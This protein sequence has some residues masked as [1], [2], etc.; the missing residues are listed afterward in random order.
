MGDRQNDTVRVD[1]DRQI[2]LE[3]HSSTVTS[4]AGLLAYRELDDALRLTN[5]AA[6]GLQDTRTG[7]NTQHS[8]VA[9]LRQSIYSRL[10]GYEDV[11][12]AERLGLDPAMRIV[13][14]GRAKDTQAASTSEMARF[15]TETLSTTENLKHLMD[16]SGQWIDQAHHHRKLTKLILDMDSSVSETYGNQEGSAYNGHFGCTCYHP[17][18]LFNQFGDLE[19]CMLRPGNVH[20]ADDWRS[21]LMPVIARY[22]GRGLVLYFR[23][24]AAFAKPELYELLEAE[25]M[26]YAIRLPAN[27]V[28]QERIGHLLTRPVGRPPRKPQVFHASFAYQ[29][30]SWSRPRRVVAKMGWTAPWRC[31]SWGPAEKETPAMSI[32]MIGLDTA[33]SVFQVHA[34]DEAGTTEVRRKLRRSGL[35]MFFDKQ[36]A[37][38]VVMEACGAAHHWARVLIGLGHEVK[39]VAP[40][41]IKPFVKKGKKNDAADAAAICQA[42]CRPD[43]RFVP[44]KSLEQQGILAV[45]SA[46]SLLVK[47]KT[48]LANAMRGL[49]TEF[50]VTVPRG[51][52]RLEELVALADVGHA[53]PGRAR[54]VIR[55][56]LEHCRILAASIEV[57]EAEIVAHARQ[58]EAARRLA[59]IP[60]VGPITASLM[61]ATV[62]DIGLFK[63]ARQFAAWLGLV[64]RQY[65]TG[66]KTRLGRIT[67]SGNRELRKSLVLGAT[68]MVYRAAAWNSAAGVWTRAMLERRPVRL[69]TVALANKMAR[70]AWALMTRKEIYHPKAPVTVEAQ[71][72]A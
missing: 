16:V 6:T 53:L 38:T 65:S 32:A 47:Q 55:E 50:G 42:A 61:A 4:D 37:C 27:A 9:L 19:R 29:A 62:A 72:V 13:V 67:K 43:I 34:V 5:T 39:L 21:V 57:L 58:D 30:Q 56:L 71:A 28:L 1:F 60:G 2:K 69:V 41:A 26:G 36:E 7:Q 64:P 11:T 22:R 51:I 59:T 12:D 40:E 66:G 18:F 35:I 10:A 68:S 8:L 23:G 48:M 31:R 3:F 25:D 44:V 49:A 15:E 20:S 45:H 17:L 52:G 46:R 54:Q 70:I 33:K 14:G 63:S 24:D